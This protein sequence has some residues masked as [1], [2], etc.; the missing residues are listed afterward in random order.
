MSINPEASSHG[1]PRTQLGALLVLLWVLASTAQAHPHHEPLTETPSP[2][3]V[4]GTLAGSF[5]VGQDG[6]AS[7]SIPLRVPPGTAGI[8]PGLALRYDSR[9]GNGIVGMGWDLDGLSAIERCSASVIQDGFDCGVNDDD[10]DRF[11]LDGERLVNTVP[12][13]SDGVCHD[14]SD[15]PYYQPGAIYH[16]EKESWRR[17]ESID[18]VDGV[19][20]GEGP[21]AF[22]VT[23]R[24]GWTWEYGA[25]DDTTSTNRAEVSTSPLAT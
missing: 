24:R 11:C 19:T 10:H 7:Y 15:D 16:T 20:C 21:C 3:T 14:D 25:P 18:S 9:A 1:S 8:Q 12:G 17:I 2:T 6:G 13:A 5:A 23:D 4:P 22:V